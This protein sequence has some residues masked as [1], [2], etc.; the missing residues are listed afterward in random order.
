MREYK[1]LTPKDKFFDGKF[2]LSRLEEALNHYARHGWVAKA[3]STP[4]VKG[5]SGVFE[6]GVVV[7]LERCKEGGSTATA[8]H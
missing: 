6:E 2:E 4:H 1:L 3:L 5:F 8:E 7:L